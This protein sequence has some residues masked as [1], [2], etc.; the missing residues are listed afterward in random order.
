MAH[1]VHNYTGEKIDVTYDAKRCIHAAECTSRLKAVFDGN[2]SPWIQPDAA[3]ADDVAA[4]IQ[5]CPSG[6]LH[7][8]RKDVDTAEPTP[9]HNTIRL[10]EDGPLYLRGNFTI[11]NGAG[12]LLLND[13]RA[14]L[15]RCGAS[16]NK[17]FC[18]NTHTAIKFTALGTVAKP[19][20]IIEP[21][22]GSPLQ[23]Q[24]TTNGSLHLTGNFTLL[25]D[26]HQAL[27][28]GT[29]EWLC[30]CGGSANNPFCDSTHK[31]IGF[32]AD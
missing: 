3:L 9:D 14:A 32:I 30:R 5:H 29:D 8:Q 12:E 2:K 7:Y 11:V 19:Q 31:K 1:K 21:L 28:Q 27:Y 22:A 24:T 16:E 15:C 4:T 25:N 6:A 18:D 26:E 20:T 13:T 23:I 10:S 17:P